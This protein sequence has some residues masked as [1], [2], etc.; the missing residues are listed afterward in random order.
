MS[1][2]ILLFLFF[3]LFGPVAKKRLPGMRRL[4]K[5]NSVTRSCVY[6]RKVTIRHSVKSQTSVKYDRTVCLHLLIKL[7]DDALCPLEVQV[8][9]LGGSVD[10][11]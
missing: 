6:V 8:T 1:E 3:F 11:C 9:D 7:I 10:I 4:N 5:Q 2:T